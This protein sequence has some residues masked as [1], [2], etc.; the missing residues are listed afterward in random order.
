MN[1]LTYSVGIAAIVLVLLIVAFEKI[2]RLTVSHLGLGMHSS[3]PSTKHYPVSYMSA[4][5]DYRDA[6]SF[7]AESWLSSALGLDK[8]PSVLAPIN[9]VLRK[10]AIDGGLSA[11]LVGQPDCT[12]D[13]PDGTTGMLESASPASVVKA[14]ESAGLTVGVPAVQAVVS[15]L[16]T[17][18]PLLS[19]S[20]QSELNTFV[21]NLIAGVVTAVPTPPPSS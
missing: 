1:P 6:T 11:A 7:V 4:P 3:L 10:A 20:E 2:P 13:N 5:S 12:T 16:I 21:S 19:T 17:Q 14:I 18:I 15:A 9:N 8:H